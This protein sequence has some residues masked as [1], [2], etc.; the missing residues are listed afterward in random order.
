MNFALSKILV[1]YLSFRNESYNV[2]YMPDVSQSQVHVFAH[3]TRH[4]TFRISD[5]PDG[6]AVCGSAVRLVGIVIGET[7]TVPSRFKIFISR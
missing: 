5:I 7:E 4:C 2:R 6:P 1:E 3:Q